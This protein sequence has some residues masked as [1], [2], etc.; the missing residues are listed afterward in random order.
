MEVPK[1][2]GLQSYQKIK[3]LDQALDYFTFSQG[4]YLLWVKTE[5]QMCT[6][7]KRAYQWELGAVGDWG[8]GIKRGSDLVE[9]AD[10]GELEKSMNAGSCLNLF[11]G[12]MA[13]PSDPQLSGLADPIDW[14]LSSPSEVSPLFSVGENLIFLATPDDSVGTFLGSWDFLLFLFGLSWL[15]SPSEGFEAT[16]GRGSTARADI[17]SSGCWL[18][19]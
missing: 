2:A 9:A 5:M 3:Y 12:C 18:Y 8:S 4:V 6:I 10:G 13:W 17:F 19:L 1:A 7:I 14:F 15:A 16:L 11:L